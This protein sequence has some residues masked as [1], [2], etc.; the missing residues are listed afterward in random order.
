MRRCCAVIPLI[1]ER[2]V[3]LDDAVAMGGFFFQD[4]V[5]P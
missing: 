5:D 1:R 3:T 2:L 4:E